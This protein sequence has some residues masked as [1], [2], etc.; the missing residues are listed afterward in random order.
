MIHEKQWKNAAL[1]LIQASII[2]VNTILFAFVWYEYYRGKMWGYTFYRRGDYVLV[3]LYF[4]LYG[5]MSK[6][7]GGIELKTS[8]IS[9]LI[10]SQTVA[11]FITNALMYLVILLLTRRPKSIL[12]LLL[13]MVIEL[14]VSAIWSYWANRLTNKI[15][16]PAKVLLVH[17]NSE[18]YRNGK[19][20]INKLPWRFNPS[21]ELKVA[22]DSNMN[23]ITDKMKKTG[24]DSLMLCGL[25][26]SQRNNVIKYCVEHDIK[27]FVRPNIGDFIIGNSQ[28]V[29]MANLPV[30]ICERATPSVV[31]TIIKRAM[32]IVI[33]L[34]GLALSSP[35]LIIT[36]ILIKAY[37]HGP[38]FY[39]Q[40][41]LTKDAKEFEILKFRSMKVDAEKDGV[42]RLSS[43]NDDRITPVG[44]VI[45]ACRIDELPQL[46]NILN[47]DLSV[48][49]PRP[50]RPEIA[51]QYMEEMPEFSLRLQVKAGLTG[52]A[53]V[54]GKYNT[55]P[56]DKLQMDLMYINKLSFVSDIKII[57]ATI[58]IL[59]M[60]ESTEGI[61]EGATTAISGSDKENNVETRNI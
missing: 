41:R 51:A 50:E 47:G 59:F 11:L 14:I 16:K 38:V 5:V 3:F 34:I 10:Y 31:Y 58:K 4:C 45:R 49:G 44:K 13:V 8:R 6:I 42:A 23:D 9:E 37:D 56:Y 22:A 7:Y 30:M 19:D 46:I 28:V 35:F 54:Y 17:D 39:K 18:A 57:F 12:P 40:V 36:A 60:P 33:S 29:Q 24:A 15:F 52:Y 55:E 2:I 61:A 26:S 32:D 20:I 53:Q 25:S 1:F 27:A 43:E 48:V 21:G